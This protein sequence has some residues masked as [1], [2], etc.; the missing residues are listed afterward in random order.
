MF[1]KTM[2]MF[3]KEMKTLFS[4]MSKKKGSKTK[5]KIKAGSKVIINGATAELLSDAIVL[6]DDPNKLM[7]SN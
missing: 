2:K 3:D 6:T 1:D 7:Q 5:I 4:R